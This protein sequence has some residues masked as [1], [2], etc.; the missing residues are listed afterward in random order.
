[1]SWFLIFK[2]REIFENFLTNVGL[3]ERMGINAPE[4]RYGISR[5]ERISR[6]HKNGPGMDEF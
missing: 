6:T 2:A 1:M 3:D 4:W 5:I